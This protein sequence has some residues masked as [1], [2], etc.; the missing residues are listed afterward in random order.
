MAQNQNPEE[1][2]QGG[3]GGLLAGRPT[4]PIIGGL[5]AIVVVGIILV[6][7]AMGGGGDKTA[8][9][10]EL[11]GLAN[12]LP[13][14]A[15]TIDLS[16]PTVVSNV[17]PN[18]NALGPADRIVISKIGINAPL[19]LKAVGLDG[20]PPDPNGPDDV[21]YYDFTAW[22]GLGGGPGKG[23]NTVL[24]GHV[25][26]GRKACNN[27]SVPPPCTAVFW[28]LRKI[29]PGDTIEMQV[30]GVSYTYKVVGADTVNATTASWEAIY[31]TSTEPMLT[32]ITC[33][34]DFSG[35][36]YDKRTVITAHLI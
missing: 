25:D 12:D 21:A 17:N 4:L 7:V 22:P 1:E 14:P 2:G 13:T 27:G 29:A 32:L 5:V 28:D 18:L 10:S 26:S 16:R 23:G 20:A 24:A 9:D 33:G 35:G 8:G 11:A 31:A 3:L 6:V 30:S 34:G 15:A 19:S 36:E